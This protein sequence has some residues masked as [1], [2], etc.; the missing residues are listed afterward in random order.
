MDNARSAERFS[1][2]ASSLPNPL[3]GLPANLQ[4]RQLGERTA[5][6]HDVLA[7]LTYGLELLRYGAML[8]AGDGRPYAANRTAL[9]I[10][11]QKDGLSLEKTGLVADRATD[12]KSLQQLLHE[13]I[14]VPASGTA[15]DSSM[16]LPR[17]AAR[18]ALLVQVA[19][20]PRLDR[21]PGTCERTALIKIYAP[22]MC[23]EADTGILIRLYGLTRGEATLAAHLVRGKSIEDAASD[24][25][26]SPHTA[27]SQLKRIFMK[28]DTHR[29]TELVVRMLPAVS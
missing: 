24:L 16:T 3:L 29:Q 22:D 15:K 27:R 10:L 12:T 4:S 19:P 13:A 20:G 17:K 28:T 1:A 26:I 11:Q 18:N 25:S 6:A 2:V 23:L 9:E 7:A 21:S 8:A 5:A 14:N